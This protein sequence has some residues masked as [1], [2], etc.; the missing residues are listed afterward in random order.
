MSFTADFPGAIVVEAAQYGYAPYKNDP[1]AWCL[2]T[3]EELA[4]NN[5]VTP[6]YFHNL[7]DRRA[8]THYFVSYTGLVF[9]MVPE[10]EGAYANAREGVAGRFDWETPNWN[11][12]LETLNV[13]I[14]GY[15][16]NIHQTM[17]RGSAQWV[18]LVRLIAHRCKALNIP[19]ERTFGHKQ[20]SNQR[21]DPGQLNIAAIIKDVNT[22]LG[23][24][25]M[26]PQEVEQIARSI[27]QKND[28]QFK[29]NVNALIRERLIAEITN[30]KNFMRALINEHTNTVT[31]G[32][33]DDDHEHD[34]VGKAK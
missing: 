14:E 8:S 31:H 32:G 30:I 34:V 22:L 1:K 16:H 27:M 29:D 9:Q 25:D 4:D 6:Y 26:T 28:Q 15:A 12:N 7:T 5:P 13:E 19:V 11:L 20:V 24:I 23:A 33:S 21:A 2:H 18:S 17:P 3:P 10:D